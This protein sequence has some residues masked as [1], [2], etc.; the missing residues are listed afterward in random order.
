M[1]QAETGKRREGERGSKVGT[2][3]GRE[4]RSHI[5]IV[6]LE[7]SSLPVSH[8]STHQIHHMVLVTKDPGV[9]FKAKQCPFPPVG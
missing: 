7:I 9:G 1:H 4:D 2:E 6:H 8:S 3:G 5:H